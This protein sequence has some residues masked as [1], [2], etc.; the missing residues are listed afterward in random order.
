MLSHVC[1][2]LLAGSLPADAKE[3]AAKQ[4]LQKMQGKWKLTELV[5]DGAAGPKDAVGATVTIEGNTMTV[6]LKGPGGK[7]EK[8]SM[9][10]TID[11]TK[12]PKQIDMKPDKDVPSLGIYE[13]KD[14]TLRICGS[15]PPK[16]KDRPANFEPK[17]GDHRVLFTLTRLK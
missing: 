6:T 4:D 15:D 7:E 5:I 10:L 16:S 12:T 13:L 1:V 9:T 2:L 8:K 14:N 11:P 17:K 3:E